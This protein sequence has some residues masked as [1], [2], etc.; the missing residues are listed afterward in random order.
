MAGVQSAQLIGKLP[1]DTASVFFVIVSTL[2]H[3]PQHTHFLLPHT[4]LQVPL[5]V[6][7]Q[8]G[9]LFLLCLFLGQ[10]ACGKHGV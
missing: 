1:A 2:C 9:T 10:S 3:L 4:P 8:H 7:V 5:P 6:A